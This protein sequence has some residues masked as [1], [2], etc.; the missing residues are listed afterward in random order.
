MKINNYNRAETFLTNSHIECL[1]HETSCQRC[2]SVDLFHPNNA[3]PLT[4]LESPY[5]AY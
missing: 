5:Y 4:S 3:A 1:F 2:Y